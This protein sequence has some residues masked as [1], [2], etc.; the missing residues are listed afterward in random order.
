MP[1]L[2]SIHPNMA[3]FLDM[4]AHSEGTTKYG[5]DDGYNVIVGGKLFDDYSAHPNILVE[6]RPGLK[7]TAAGR[8]QLLFRYYQPYKGLLKLDDFSP[9]SQDKI[10]IQ[11]IKERR[12]MPLIETGHFTDAVN[13]CKN[14]WASLPGAGYGQHEN[15]IGPLRMAYVAA[16]GILLG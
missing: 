11:Q 1:R 9:A 3:A 13:A 15:G 7:S 16:G 14:I 6:L 12:A 8:Y 10:A 4:L 2:T 5:H